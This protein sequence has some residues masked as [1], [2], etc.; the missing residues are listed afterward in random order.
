MSFEFQPSERAQL[1]ARALAAKGPAQV[2]A[3]NE[4]FKELWRQEGAEANRRNAATQHAERWAR[5]D[6]VRQALQNAINSPRDVNYDLRVR[7]A[8]RNVA[9]VEGELP[10][11]IAHERRDAEEA[12]AQMPAAVPAVVEDASWL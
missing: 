7:V 12:Q 10:D 6:A 1:A 4:E 9:D 2:A 8:K 11:L 3:V 5:L